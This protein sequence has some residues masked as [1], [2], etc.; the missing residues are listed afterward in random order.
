MINFE[1]AV[2]SY[3]YLHYGLLRKIHPTYYS[4]KEELTDKH[5]IFNFHPSFLPSILFYDRETRAPI[6]TVVN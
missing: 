4:R 2:E 3:I 6:S 5:N 1:D